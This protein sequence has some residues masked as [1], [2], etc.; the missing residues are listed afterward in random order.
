MSASAQRLVERSHRLASVAS[1]PSTLIGSLSEGA[2]TRLSGRRIYRY[3]SDS[4]DNDV[5]D[6]GLVARPQRLDC[7]ELV[8]VLDDAAHRRYQ[9]VVELIRA[10]TPVRSH[11]ESKRA[12][13]RAPRTP[14]SLTTHT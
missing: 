11:V 13:T 4:S 10:V 7:H 5:A 14:C 2:I 12:G 9:L 1:P 8:D 3:L 6:V